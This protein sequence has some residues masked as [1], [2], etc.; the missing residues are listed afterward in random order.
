MFPSHS[1]FR[2]LAT[3][4]IIPVV[5]LG[6]LWAFLL[7]PPLFRPFSAQLDSPDDS[8]KS[9]EVIG[10]EPGLCANVTPDPVTGKKMVYCCLDEV[11]MYQQEAS[12]AELE[13][14]MQ[15]LISLETL[16]APEAKQI[17]EAPYVGSL[18]IKYGWS[19]LC[20]KQVPC[21]ICS[22]SHICGNSTIE[23]PEQCDDG[24]LNAD[25][26]PDA[27][28]LDCTRPRC[29][30]G[31]LDP[32]H[33]EEC[34]DGPEND[35]VSGT[36]R[37][38]CTVPRCGDGTVDAA[39][40]EICDEGESNADDV[41]DRCRND[42]RPPGCGDGVVD[43]LSGE[44]CDDGNI[45]DGDGCSVECASEV[46]EAIMP[47]CGDGTRDPGEQCDDGKK[48]ARIPDA[49]RPTC[50]L[51][52]CGD[53]IRDDG[54]RCDDGNV[55]NGDGCTRVCQRELSL[56]LT[57]V[58]GNGAIDPGEE[59]D[60]GEKNDNI[61][62]ACR[63]DCTFPR[64]GDH[65]KDRKDQCDD[66]NTAGGDGCSARCFVE[67]CGD[68]AV[69]MN[70]ECDDGNLVGGDGCSSACEK[71][72][73][74]SVDPLA[75][76][77]HT[78]STVTPPR[79]TAPTGTAAVLPATQSAPVVEGYAPAP[80]SRPAAPVATQMTRPVAPPSVPL[81]AP[82]VPPAS[83]SASLPPPSLALPVPPSPDIAPSSVTSRFPPIPSPVAD[84]ATAEPAP[85]PPPFT[86]SFTSRG[87]ERMTNT[88]PAAIS[89]IAMGSAA[90]LAWARRKKRH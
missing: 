54:E 38:T 78:G 24:P 68:G 49:C 23:P 6:V 20:G 11:Y 44:T 75:D 16:R 59:C 30:D 42:C 74:E 40:G 83:P 15:K 52:R 17:F 4:L 60:A 64:C 27:C 3:R 53:G 67:F 18:H 46:K 45:L 70:E 87:A 13:T 56:S 36:C 29:G 31:V 7:A 50:V 41:P 81:P 39:L 89:V 48:N 25:D 2:R 84:S 57:R 55:V 37:T 82:V 28:R 8:S 34:D 85:K 71:E 61:P 26:V 14:F 9:G 43:I 80:G 5:L 76:Y 73:G 22:Q 51:P 65:I 77:T 63:F 33:E 58:C 72:I 86:L 21:E 88:G 12:P 90:G 47:S 32:E 1:P 62:D 10:V 69:Q 19:S 35:D 79:N 66:G